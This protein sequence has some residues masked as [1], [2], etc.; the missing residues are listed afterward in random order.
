[1]KHPFENQGSRPARED[2]TTQELDDL[3]AQD[4]AAGQDGLLDTEAILAMTEVI[5]RREEDTP[6]DA[7]VQAAWENFRAQVREKEEG[8]EEAPAEP[9]PLP[10][11]PRRPRKLR[12]AVSVAA[13]V[14]VLVCILVV[15]A[16]GKDLWESLAHWTESTFSLGEVPEQDAELSDALMTELE[17]QVA[18]LTDLPVLP[19]WYPEGALLKQ[20]E[21]SSVAGEESICAVFSW[22]EEEFSVVIMVHDTAPSSLSGYEKN[23]GPPKEYFAN[24]I[25][26]YIMGNMD[27]TI[28]VWQNETVEC[29]IQ[30]YFTEE[31]IMRMIDSI[32]E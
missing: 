17:S 11:K 22:K 21:T 20:I 29:F 14:C 12:W 30:G 18:E 28:A 27:R 8:P 10:A 16:S 6:A 26:H 9:V 24:G 13:V 32:Y 4:F 19:K 5:N 25:P 31:E 1:M 3:L 7:D 15:P 23:P 2:L